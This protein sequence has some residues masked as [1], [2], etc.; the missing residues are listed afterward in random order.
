[1]TEASI[2]KGKAR[3]VVISQDASENTKRKFEN[4]CKYYEVPICFL[5]DRDTLGSL[6]GKGPR[7]ALSIEDDGFAKA[8]AKKNQIPYGGRGNVRG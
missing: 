1:M 8:F 2:H 5:S 3:L 4:A 6:V 7:T